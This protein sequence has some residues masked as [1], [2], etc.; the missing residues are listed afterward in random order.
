M[1]GI[2]MDLDLRTLIIF[3]K[4]SELRS[5]VRTA[6]ALDITQAGV[7]NAI[8][9]LETQLGTALLAR[10]TRSVNLTVDGEAFFHRCKQVIAD[11]EDAR[12]VL[13]RARRQPTGTLRIS[14]PVSFGRLQVVPLLGQFQAKYPSVNVT[15][16]ITDRY[17]NLVDEGVDIAVRFGALEDS[18]LIARPLTNVHRHVVGTPAYFAK[19]GKPKT[20]AEL[21]QH[22]CLPLTFHES[23]RARPWK[24][25]QDG[26][27]LALTPKGSMNFNDGYALY[28][29]VKAGIGLGQIHDYYVE[30]DI[31][32]GLLIPVLEAFEPEADAFSI[33]YPKAR[34]LSPRVRAFV[35]FL[36]AAY[37]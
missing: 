33:V 17:V 15:I 27:V 6:E 37:Q 8:K 36:V 20:L 29:A 34:H 16:S 19:H 2:G 1:N 9:R 35:D 26:E 3:V 25:Q 21:A 30:A 12:Q 7:S 32:A 14:L 28:I 31:S 23:G 22:N 5:F 18:S 4:V 24:F 10:T 11:L 13:T